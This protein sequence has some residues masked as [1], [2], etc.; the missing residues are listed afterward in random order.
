MKFE[1]ILCIYRN[2]QLRL[3]LAI[4]C[5]KGQFCQYLRVWVIFKNCL[6]GFLLIF[7]DASFGAIKFFFGLFFIG[8]LTGSGPEM[9]IILDVGRIFRPDLTYM[10]CF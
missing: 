7:Q 6:Q 3:Y 9:T 4:Y 8:S 5:Q 2:E 10:T 1:F